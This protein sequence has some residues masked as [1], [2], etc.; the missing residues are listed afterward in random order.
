MT[1]SSKIKSGR[2][3]QGFDS[4]VCQII[5]LNSHAERT[6]SLLRKFDDSRAFAKAHEGYRIYDDVTRDVL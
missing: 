6:R 3:D 1:R 5:E 4:N 2:T